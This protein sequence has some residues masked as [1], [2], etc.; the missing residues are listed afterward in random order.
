MKLRYLF[1]MILSSVLLL[2]S[3]V[4]ENTASW[5]N[6]KLSATYLSISE[7]GGTAELT[8][9]ATEDWAFVEAA[10]EWLTIDKMSGAAGETVVTFSAE[11]T[12]SGREAEL[13]IKAGGN[14]Q[15]LRV[16]Q[17]SLEASSATCAEVIAGPDGKTYRVK[18]TVTAIANTTYGNWYLNDGT[19]EVY[20]Y[21]TLDKDGKTKNFASL[22]IEVGDVVEVEGPKLTYGT[23]VELVDV[24]VLSIEK[25]LLKIITPEP[26]VEAEGGEIVVEV[27][28]KGK[29]MFPTISEDA[30]DWLS[31]VSTETKFGEPT[32]IEPNPADTAVVKIK[33]AA[34][35]EFVPKREGVVSFSS[36]MK[37]DDNEIVSTETKFTITQTG[38]VIPTIA[39]VIAAGATAS[40]KTQGVIVAKYTRGALISDGTGYILIYKNAAMEE[41]VGDKIE[42]NGPTSLYGGMLQF[43]KDAVVTKLSS[44]NAVI[45]PEPTVLDAAGMDA[46]LTKTAVEYIEYVGTLSVNGNYYNVTVEGTSTAMGSLQYIDATEFPAAVDGAEIKVRGYFI[47]VSSGKYVNTMT[48]AVVDPDEEIAEPT[49]P[50]IAEVIAGGAK[51]EAETKGVVVATYTRGALINDGTASILLYNNAPLDVVVGDE[52]KVA[53]KTT[54]YAGMLQFAKDGLVVT[55]LSSGHTVNHPAPTVLDAAGMNA[56]LAKKTVE[57]IE[58][59]GTLS[60]SGN[61]YNVNVDGTTTAIGSLQYIDAAAH[62]AATDGAKIKVRG[63]FIGVSSGK[64][65]NTMTVAVEAAE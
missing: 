2:S 42:V 22:G 5:D 16:R 27:A 64:Y 23:T 55:K 32:K 41:V 14:T 51:D 12:T 3:C 1:S 36:S 4:K 62:P 7:E 15:Y 48:V 58:Y 34:F 29:G 24:T 20:V 46:Q 25:A 21:G 57:Y 49:L 44:G 9:T 52:V 50:T 13:S 40:A 39:E 53:G 63:Y 61:Y 60:V 43:T 54:E 11:K 56:Q 30:Q 28:Y 17:G 45:H 19:G 8:V 59:V 10:P 47:G 37:N 26:T 33:V 6:I 31:I 65:V 18:G 38:L 35:E